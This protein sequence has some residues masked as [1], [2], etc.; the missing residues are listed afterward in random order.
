MSFILVIL[1]LYI[2]ISSYHRRYQ[3]FPRAVSTSRN[4][5]CWLTWMTKN[6]S[7]TSR[8][9]TSPR[10]LEWRSIGRD[11]SRKSVPCPSTEQLTR[12]DDCGE[13]PP[14][15][16]G[17]PKHPLFPWAQNAP[18]ENRFARL[19]SLLSIWGHNFQSHPS[20]PRLPLL[21][22]AFTL[23]SVVHKK[24]S[25]CPTFLQQTPFQLSLKHHPSNQ[26]DVAHLALHSSLYH[27]LSH[28]LHYPYESFGVNRK[29]WI[30]IIHS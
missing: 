4:G 10:Q 23:A 30:V 12:S 29:L 14:S 8:H 25:P 13:S 2:S 1:S 21:L 19:L 20:A 24:H 9:V 17:K 22:A 15:D 5:Q 28:M 3:S 16:I 6:A 18:S 27:S 7:V 11:S 26:R